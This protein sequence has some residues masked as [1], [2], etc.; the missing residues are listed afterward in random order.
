MN[1]NKKI[2]VLAA[3]F[4]LQ[5]VLQFLSGVSGLIEGASY[6]E[7]GN[8]F[9]QAG[10]MGYLGYLIYAT[11][12]KWVYWSAMFFVGL[13]MIRFVIGSGLIA[14]FGGTPSAGQLTLVV[15]TIVVFG[16]I[17]LLLLLNKELRT[18]YLSQNDSL[19]V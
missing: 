15:F 4:G 11:R 14:Y 2:L 10:V 5:S 12:K 17:P 3:L 9:A 16:I 6:G 19:T 1:Q 13:A 18:A 8:S 7:Y